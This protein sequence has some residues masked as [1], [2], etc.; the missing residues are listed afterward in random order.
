MS[1]NAKSHKQK[2]LSHHL[3]IMAVLMIILFFTNN[4]HQESGPFC[5][6]D[7]LADYCAGI[8]DSHI[9]HKF[10]N[11]TTVKEMKLGIEK[12]YNP[13][14][15]NFDYKCIYAYKN[16]SPRIYSLLNCF[17]KTTTNTT[18]INY[19]NTTLNNNDNGKRPGWVNDLTFGLVTALKKLP[20][21]ELE[22][23]RGTAL[24]KVP[25][26]GDILQNTGF[27]S[28]SKSAQVAANFGYGQYLLRFS[29]SGGRDITGVQ[30]LPFQGELE[31]IIP[32]GKCFEVKA[33]GNSSQWWNDLASSISPSI[34]NQ[35]TFIE[36]LKV[37][38]PGKNNNNNNN[39]GNIN[40]RQDILSLPT[41]EEIQE[42][43]E[44]KENRKRNLNSF[45]YT[46][47]STG[48]PSNWSCSPLSFGSGDGCDCNC[49]AWDPDCNVKSATL[50][51]CPKS[52]SYKCSNTTS[53]NGVCVSQ[54]APNG[55]PIPSDW[56][57]PADY[58]GSGDGCDCGCGAWDPDCFGQTIGSY[59]FGCLDNQFCNDKGVC[60]D[61]KYVPPEWTCEPKYFN[62]SDGC[63]CNCGS[64]LDPDCLDTSQEVLNCPCTT[65]TCNLGYCEGWCEGVYIQATQG[66]NDPITPPVDTVTGYKLGELIGA[67]IA[68]VLGGIVLGSIVAVGVIHIHTL[69]TNK[70]AK[71]L[72]LNENFIQH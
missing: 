53:Q 12:V 70:A 67:I 68:S 13:G 15:T 49:G 14:L 11:H 4:F 51:N 3:S 58:Y 8:L 43:K 61:K 34:V 33:F 38:C 17:L 26:V 18:N 66:K 57:C 42:L 23:F 22:T 39:G 27:V 29:K 20:K 54:F 50:F 71:R 30:G 25:K 72:E 31:V 6:A 64:V 9:S 44:E 37:K 21:Y 69:R 1:T 63:D 10:N 2:S 5:K 24:D 60:Q 46:A 32:P 55:A 52:G 28:T 41:V 7:I 40:I 48:V 56:N 62:A 36:L 65:M 45:Y 16:E 35:I 47:A 59:A 19:S